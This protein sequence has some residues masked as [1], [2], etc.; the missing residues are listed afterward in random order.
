MRTFATSAGKATR[1]RLII[2]QPTMKRRQESDYLGPVD[3]METTWFALITL[4]QNLFL[5]L[6]MNFGIEEICNDDWDKL[7]GCMLRKG[8]LGDFDWLDGWYNVHLI[9]ENKFKVWDHSLGL[10]RSMAPL[11]SNWQIY[12]RTSNEEWRSRQRKHNPWGGFGWPIV[13]L[14]WV[15]V[16]L[17]TSTGLSASPVGP[18]GLRAALAAAASAASGYWPL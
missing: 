4:Q 12:T 11:F 7:F 8:K 1:H 15:W 13:T 2:N 5:T 6:I 3:V 9:C 18:R 10:I 17:S 16:D 14:G